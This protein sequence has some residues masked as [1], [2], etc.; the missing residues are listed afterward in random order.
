MLITTPDLHRICAESL[1]DMRTV[2]KAYAGRPVSQASRSLIQIV[3]ER[4]GLHPPP[5]P[6]LRR[7]GA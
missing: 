3:A 6:T 4:L 7:R 1:L 2:A 5:L